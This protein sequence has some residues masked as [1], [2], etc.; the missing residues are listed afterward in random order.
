[1]PSTIAILSPKP[2]LSRQVVRA[3]FNRRSRVPTTLQ[4]FL[5]VVELPLL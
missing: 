1:V 3:I 2:F 5:H 4:N